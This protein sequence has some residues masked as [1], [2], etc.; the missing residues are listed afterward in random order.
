M[1]KEYYSYSL[2]GSTTMH[3]ERFHPQLHNFLIILLESEIVCS[4][5][6]PLI[7]RATSR[8]INNAISMSQS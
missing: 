6:V 4:L 7:N 8:G 2:A 3:V 1:L 5:F